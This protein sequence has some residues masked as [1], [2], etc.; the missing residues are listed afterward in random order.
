MTIINSVKIY[1]AIKKRLGNTL[2]HIIARG[3]IIFINQFTLLIALPILAS[4]LD[5]LT[6]G[7]VAIGLMTIQIS[8]L[9][10]HWGIHNYSIEN[11]QHLKNKSQKN[12]LITM[13]GIVGVVNG[14]IFLSFILLINLK[15]WLNIPISLIVSMIPSILI[16]G[17][18]PIWFFQIKK[19]TQK[20]ILP[21]FSARMIYLLIILVFI[22]DNSDAYIFFLAQALGLVIVC[23]YAFSVMKKKYTHKISYFNLNEFKNFYLKNTPYF[24]NSISNNKINTLW[25]SGL[26]IIGGPEA[27][28]L[29]NLGDEI[30]R[31]GSSISNI[32]AQAIRINFL[33]NKTH[34]LKVVNTIFTIFYFTLAILISSVVDPAIKHFFSRNYEDASSIIKIMVFAWAINATV[35]LINYPVLGRL[36]GIEWLNKITYQIFLLHIVMFVFWAMVFDSALSFAVFFTSVNLIQL[37]LYYFFYITYNPS[38]PYRDKNIIKRRN[39]WGE[40]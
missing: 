12:Q 24:F 10:S 18:N 15:G 22:K 13:A 28:A 14:I 21:T 36:Y 23:F 33:N 31:F 34:N 35:K 3:S 6:F 5:F 29:Y 26:S 25:G 1:R 11:W 37:I 19:A 4:R 9:I 30:Y 8:W 20:L 27:M 17:I 16:G 2:K 32:I 40:K 39:Y 7:K 38:N